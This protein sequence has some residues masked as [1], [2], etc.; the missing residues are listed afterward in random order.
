MNNKL[1]SPVFV[2]L[3]LATLAACQTESLPLAA[4]TARPTSF[5]P[6]TET[7]IEAPT[8]APTPATPSAAEP[9]P[10][11]QLIALQGAGRWRASDAVEWDCA[12]IGQ[13]LALEN[14]V[15][16]ET[17]AKAVIQY[18][19]GLL[20]HVAPKTLFTVTELHQAE[21]NSLWA[22]IRLLV[23]QL[24]VS[25]VGED[26]SQIR[27]ETEAG[28]AGVRGTMMSVKVT[29][30]GR[31]ILT[32]LEGVCTL[33]NDYGL[34]V[35][36]AGQQAELLNANTPPVFLGAIANYQFNEWFANHPEAL[37]V[38]L[39]NGLLAPL[40]PGCSLEES[41]SCQ[42]ELDCDPNT[43]AGCQL[44]GGCNPV[45]G[46]GCELPGSC[47]PVTGEGCGLPESCD[48]LSGEGCQLGTGCNPVNG[49]GCAQPLNC[50]PLTGIGC[51]PGA[52]CDPQT[53]QG[54]ELPSG[55]N[56]IT[57]EGCDCEGGIGCAGGPFPGGQPAPADVPPADAPGNGDL[58]S[59]GD[60]PG[61]GD[62]PGEGDVPDEVDIP[63]E[64]DLPAIPPLP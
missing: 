45:T 8:D 46:E 6:A 4:P 28:I 39:N 58:P 5:S 41:L 11:A 60:I 20:V 61:K 48:P 13:A 63:D 21:D 26:G 40:P 10:L 34:I 50:N 35:L 23:G 19:D 30:S 31:V 47:N 49:Q 2:L 42:I 36:Q 52:E 55:C 54:C 14:Q 7:V 62:I 24:F 44:P 15:L 17:D 9:N 12:S 38:A 51:Q 1:T 32:C 59:E 57:G 37:L 27:V 56:P 18:L 22:T 16:T 33:E 25:Y 29:L 64:E 53:G 3:L 43:G